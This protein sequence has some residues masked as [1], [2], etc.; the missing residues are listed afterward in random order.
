M[1]LA[2]KSSNN[3]KFSE[4]QA[5]ELRFSDSD[6]DIFSEKQI[7]GLIHEPLNQMPGQA[8]D[9]AASRPPTILLVEDAEAVRKLVTR[10]LVWNGY[11]VLVGANGNAALKLWSEHKDEIDLLLTDI[12]MPDGPNGRHL[13]EEMI[14]ECSTLKVLFTSGYSIQSVDSGNGPTPGKNFL[15]KPYRPEQLLA[16]VQSVLAGEPISTGAAC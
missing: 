5:G 6:A 15:P 11:R 10:L 4:Y 3:N 2:A 14:A 16:A 13:A 1:A 8:S 12:V 9:G 7:M